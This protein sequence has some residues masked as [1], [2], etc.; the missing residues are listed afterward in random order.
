MKIYC[1]CCD[2]VQPVRIDN[3]R[4]AKTNEPF[5]DIVCA[6]CDLVIVSGIDIAPPE[7]V[8]HTVEQPDDWSEWVCP[9]PKGYLM[10]CCDCGL[11][12]EAEFGVVRYKSET[13]REDCDMVDDPNLQ[14]VF[15]MRRSEQWSPAD[16]AHRAGGLPMAEQPAQDNT[17]NYAKNLAEAM[18]KRH[19][20]SDEHYASGRIVWGVND[21]VIGILTQIDNMVADM[22]RRPAQRKPLTDEQTWKFKLQLEKD[23]EMKIPEKPFR[24]VVR[25]IEAAHGI[26]GDA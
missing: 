4:D 23:A 15:R 17:Y 25:A 14:A 16:T 7:F 6:E 2:K 22:V 20:A 11:V 18:F 24:H 8:T 13:E 10:K 9:D 3:C 19:F 26:K 12:H 21:T 1:S 5:Q